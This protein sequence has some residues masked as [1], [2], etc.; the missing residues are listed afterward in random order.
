MLL[1]CI[2]DETRF[3]MLELLQKNKELCVNDLVSELKKDQPLV[4]HHLKSLKQCGIV[5]SRESGKMTMYS[6]ANKETSHLISDITKASEKIA[7]ICKDPTCC[8]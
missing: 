2:C 3:K 8:A 1:K 5:H 6:I 4:S 7:A